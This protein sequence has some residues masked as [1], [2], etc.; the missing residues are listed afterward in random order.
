MSDENEIK[1]CPACGGEM[2]CSK[3]RNSAYMTRYQCWHDDPY[4]KCEY[5]MTADF[6][7]R[8]KAVEAHNKQPARD[9]DKA[10]ITELEA[11]IKQLQDDYKQECELHHESIAKNV[12]MQAE[13]QE[14]KAKLERVR[15]LCK[16]KIHNCT[17]KEQ[18]VRTEK[19]T[20]FIKRILGALNDGE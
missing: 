3:F 4:V 19:E 8:E 10:R 13:N 6:S 1:N 5:E 7:T 12:I 20:G 16:T 17:Y 11:K 14:L 9:A 18:P 15:V 2:V